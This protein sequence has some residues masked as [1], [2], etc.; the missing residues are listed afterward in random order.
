MTMLGLAGGIDVSP[1]SVAALGIAAPRHPAGVAAWPLVPTRGRRL[2]VMIAL[3][4]VYATAV[5]ALWRQRY[6][7]IRPP[8]VAPVDLYAAAVDWS[9][10]TVT[11]S[12]ADA[13]IAWTTTA[14]DVRRNVMLWRRMRLVNWNEVPEPVRQQSL[15]N[16]FE[17]YRGVLLN[18][19]AW[20]VMDEHDWDLVPQPM[21]T[22]AYREMVAYWAG[23]YDVGE[24][25]G[26]SPRLVSDTL[27]AIVMSESW[28]EHR[29]HYVNRDATT[30]IGL[31]AASDFARHRLRQLHA[32]GI[33]DVA[34]S[35]DD[36]LDP[37]KATRF[38]AIW[39][40]LLLDEARGDLDLAVRAYNRGIGHARD[41]LG[42]AYLEMVNRRL[43]RFI[44]NAGTPAAWDYVWRRAR[45]LERQ[46]WPWMIA[47]RP[48]PSAPSGAR[49]SVA[50]ADGAGSA[51]MPDGR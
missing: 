17:R 20:D 21:R 41:S 14:D 29:G 19:A 39:M 46:D 25:Y 15:D 34:L 9:P 48:E 5:G 31:G 6:L 30:D 23:Y 51:L 28:F 26:L 50:S 10:V 45:A 24:R 36:Y 40:S 27:A 35:D 49:E 13:L 16:M 47:Q 37:W 22:V 2:L 18:P 32:Q 43:E 38:V 8:R 3:L 12:A 33:V 42:T 11:Y 4:L 7:D 44:R 1:G